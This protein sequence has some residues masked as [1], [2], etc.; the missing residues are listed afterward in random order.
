VSEL[1]IQ[2]SNAAKLIRA[3]GDAVGLAIA[4]VLEDFGERYGWRVDVD[5]R[6]DPAVEYHVDCEQ[7]LD[8]CPCIRPYLALARASLTGLFGGAA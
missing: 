1:S 6:E 2:L 8:E 3:H 5:A 7:E 4:D